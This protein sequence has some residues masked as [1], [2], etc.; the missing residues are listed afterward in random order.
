MAESSRGGGK[1]QVGGG[2]R[3]EGMRRSGNMTEVRQIRQGEIVDDLE[4]WK[5]GFWNSIQSFCMKG[6][7]W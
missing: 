3:S 4:W 5:E 2:E 6:R 7:T 1:S